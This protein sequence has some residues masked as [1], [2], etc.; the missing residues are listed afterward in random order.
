MEVT[1][2]F[3]SYLQKY[4]DEMEKISQILSVLSTIFALYS[5]FQTPNIM[6]SEDFS[7]YEQKY[8]PINSEIK[9]W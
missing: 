2:L 8:P 1:Y 3:W 4:G 5:S 7:L 9:F 6:E